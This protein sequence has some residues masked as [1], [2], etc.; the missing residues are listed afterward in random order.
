MERYDL[1]QGQE[2]HGYDG[3]LHVSRGG[4]TS[5][6]GE[7]FINVAKSLYGWESIDDAQDFHTINKTSPWAKWINP[8]NGRRSDAAHGYVHP[9]LDTQEN[10]HLLVE[11]KVV[12]V[13]FE[14]TKAV[15]VE[16][17][18]KYIP[19]NTVLTIVKI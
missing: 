11:S 9:I 16:Y 12:R 6:L 15:G 18:R 8:H 4:S 13:L 2:S 19:S 3:P 14:G 7:E 1:E 17:V 5:A 10:L